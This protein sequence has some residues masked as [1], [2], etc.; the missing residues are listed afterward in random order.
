MKHAKSSRAKA[1]RSRRNPWRGIALGTLGAALLIFA[2][3]S[4]FGR[5][6]AAIN[7]PDL[8]GMGF[9]ADGRQL[10]VAVHDGLRVFEDGR[11]SNPNLPAHDYMGYS[12]SD[13]GFYSSGHPHPSSGMRNPFG[14]VKSSDGGRRLVR[15]GFEGESDFHLMGVGYF[16]HALYVFNPAPNSR[17]APGLHYSLD[18]GTTWNQSALQG[19]AAGPIQ[20]SVHPTEADTLAIPTEAGLFLS[21]D[22]G[23]TFELV[24]ETAPVTAVSFNPNGEELLS[25]YQSLY[26][27]SLAT[28]QVT[29]LTAPE[30]SSQDA[31]AY[32]AMN[33]QNA[34]E[35]ALATFEKDIYLSKNSGQS[36]DQIAV[37]GKGSGGN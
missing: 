27:Y 15:L 8:H 11:W 23:N 9:S 35:I 1:R 18:D 6:Q 10:I 26:T 31:I 36:W 30:I 22:F 5:G 2:G 19:L 14:L 7:F 28:K 3:W 25:G 17:L 20:I 24:G 37:E 12:P 16:S 21:S 29:P 32:I 4:A 13:E 34:D 33:P